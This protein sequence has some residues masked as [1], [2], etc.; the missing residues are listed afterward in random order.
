MDCFRVPFVT[1]MGRDALV[2]DIPVFNPE[3]QT[4]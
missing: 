1:G 3:G 4:R 2:V